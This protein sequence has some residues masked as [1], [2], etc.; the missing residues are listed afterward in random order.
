MRVEGVGTCAA[1]TAFAGAAFPTVV[2]LRTTT[3]LDLRTTT[4]KCEAVPRRARIQGSRTCVSPNS[5]LESDKEE[6]GAAPPQ[7]FSLRGRLYHFT[8][9]CCGNEAGSYLSLMDSCITQLKAPGLSRTCNERK[10]E[11]EWG[12]APPQPLSPA[13][14][15][16]QFSIQEQV[17]RRIVKRFRGSLV[18]KARRLLYHSS[19]GRE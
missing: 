16:R 2:D 3:F 1:T 13:Q 9:M 19:L 10:R 15:S 6:E 11:E 18:F 17:L 12:P 7:P 4:Q 5:R 14:P 8:E